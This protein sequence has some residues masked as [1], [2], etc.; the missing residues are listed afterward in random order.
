MEKSWNIS[1]YVIHSN[2]KYLIGAWYVPG[3]FSR[4][5]QVQ[6]WTKQKLCLHGPSFLLWIGMYVGE[7]GGKRPKINLKQSLVDIRK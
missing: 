2:N 5:W 7:G 3:H 4:F 6:Q 1:L